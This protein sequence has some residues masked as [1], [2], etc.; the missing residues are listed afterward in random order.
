MTALLKVKD[1]VDQS[2]RTC[3]DLLFTCVVIQTTVE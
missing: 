1:R 3:L 2:S